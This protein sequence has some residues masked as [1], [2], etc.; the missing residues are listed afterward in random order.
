MPDRAP[1]GIVGL[2]LMGEVFSRRLIDAQ[3][4]K[5]FEPVVHASYSATEITTRAILNCSPSLGFM[6]G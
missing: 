2:G 4:G 3:W 6:H 1:V 5:S